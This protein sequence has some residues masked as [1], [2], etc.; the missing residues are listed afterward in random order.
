M[1][2]PGL[3]RRGVYLALSS[4]LLGYG[5]AQCPRRPHPGRRGHCS[6]HGSPA[7]FLPGSEEKGVWPERAPSSFQALFSTLRLSAFCVVWETGSQHSYSAS[8]TA[9]G[10]VLSASRRW[11]VTH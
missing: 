2:K 1:D 11:P 10:C 8:H 9:V 4:F 7:V 3:Q 6:A 5:L